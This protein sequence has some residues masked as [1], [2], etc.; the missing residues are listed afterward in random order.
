MSVQESVSLLWPAAVG[1]AAGGGLRPWWADLE[2]EP[3]A[4]ALAYDGPSGQASRAVLAGL[5]SDGETILYRQEILA[6]LWADGQLRQ[7]LADLLPALHELDRVRVQA[8]RDEDNQLLQVARRLRELELYSD[9]ACR[10]LSVLEAATLQSTGLI[11]LRD[12]LRQTC[13]SEDFR[14]LV[15]ELPSLRAS[16]QKLSSISVGINLDDEGRPVAAVLLSVN[17]Q[18]YG[19][20]RSLLARLLGTGNREAI[21]AGI[22]PLHQ[23]AAQSPSPFLEHLFRDLA[24]VMRLVCRPIA[25]ALSGYVHVAVTP[26]TSLAPEIAF[27]LGAVRLRERLHA[28]GLPTCIPT[29][30]PPEARTTR[31]S[32]MYNVCLSLRLLAKPP[33]AG[34]PAVP[35]PSD[36]NMG[37][38]GR[39]FILTGPNLGGKTTYLQAIGLTHVM[40]QAGLFVPATAAEISP[41]DAIHT[42]F[43]AP[44][45]PSKAMG[46]LGEEAQRLAQIFE[47]ATP[48]SLILLNES[49]SSTSPGEALYLARDVVSAL[50][51]LGAR[52]VFATHLHELANDLAGLSIA[53]PHEPP[54]GSLVAGIRRG[55][56]RLDSARLGRTYRI[57]PGPPEGKSYAQEVAERHG[58]SLAQLRRCLRRRGIS[59][60]DGS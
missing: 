58:I 49:L 10:L 5:C 1:A 46:R 35:V 11:R 37:E 29:L 9:A 3:L 38:D 25:Q 48:R 12:A 20:K 27:Y 13:G 42:H 51:L 6:D 55:E 50:H 30:L 39:C 45:Q 43:P 33:A 54:V 57:A 56:E 31:L 18:P 59:A 41:V 4:Q 40:A 44:E 22:A 26:L 2:V 47:Q 8:M 53:T 19:S 17:D 16:M 15:S 36:V 21:A 7:G 28:S 60:G 14:R 34:M 24:E 52:S 32:G 23:V